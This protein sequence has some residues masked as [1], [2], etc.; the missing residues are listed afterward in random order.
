VFVPRCTPRIYRN[1]LLGAVSRLI[2]VECARRVAGRVVVDVGAQTLHDELM[3][4]L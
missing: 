1:C 4:V 3:L 2:I